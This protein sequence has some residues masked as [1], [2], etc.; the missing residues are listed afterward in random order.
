MQCALEL[1]LFHAVVRVRSACDEAI[2]PMHRD[3]GTIDCGAAQGRLATTASP[4]GAF[5]LARALILKKQVYSAATLFGALS[6]PGSCRSKAT[7]TIPITAQAEMVS[8]PP[9]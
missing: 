2:Q 4:F 3:C 9:V 5:I 8:I 1:H 6:N 7:T